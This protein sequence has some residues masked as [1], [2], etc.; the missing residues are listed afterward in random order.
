ML[1]DLIR[2]TEHTEEEKEKL[3]AYATEFI[4]DERPIEGTDPHL[5]FFAITVIMTV[6]KQLK[7]EPSMF[8]EMQRK[9]D[10]FVIKV[11]KGE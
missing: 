8:F 9:G 7:G 5:F 4:V 2:K 3:F 1:N 6:L 11:V 10:N